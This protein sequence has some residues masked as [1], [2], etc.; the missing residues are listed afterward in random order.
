MACRLLSHWKGEDFG[1]GGLVLE[2]GTSSRAGRL[3][4]CGVPGG[5]GALEQRPPLS[6]SCGLGAQWGPASPI[7]TLPPEPGA[8]HAPH[9]ALTLVTTDLSFTVPPEMTT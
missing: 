6:P 1:K 2:H 7:T 3:G 9:D 4:P 8:P 5:Q